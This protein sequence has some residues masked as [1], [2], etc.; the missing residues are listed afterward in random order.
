M[1]APIATIDPIRFV[2]IVLSF[3]MRRSGVHGSRHA[4]VADRPRHPPWYG[5]VARDR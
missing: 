4:M 3:A 2:I 5:Y 1:A